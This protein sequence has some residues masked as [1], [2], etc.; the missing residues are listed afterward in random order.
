MWT[1]ACNIFLLA[2][3]KTPPP[4]WGFLRLFIVPCEHEAAR[5]GEAFCSCLGPGSLM[6]ATATN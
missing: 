6:N 1:L 3:E 5:E 4:P 2:T